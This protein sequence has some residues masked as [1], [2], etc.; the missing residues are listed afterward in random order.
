MSLEP[1]RSSQVRCNGLLV[2]I[3]LYLM[4]YM[5]TDSPMTAPPP[6]A[7]R[8]YPVGGLE[9]LNCRT[10]HPYPHPLIDTMPVPPPTSPPPLAGMRGAEEATT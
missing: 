9:D 10:P 2:Y 6:S 1:V 7:S 3:Q 8:S 4:C 5:Q